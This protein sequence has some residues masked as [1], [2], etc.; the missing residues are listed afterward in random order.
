[1][2]GGLRIFWNVNGGD[3]GYNYPQAKAHGF[4]LI[5]LLN[6][7]SDYPG[8]G[9]EDITRHANANPNNPWA[10]PEF[11]E[12]I[13]RRNIES[14]KGKNAIFVHDIEFHFEDEPQDALARCPAVKPIHDKAPAEFNDSYYREWA[15]WFALPC[16]WTKEIYPN[17]PVGL[18]GPQP[19]R[20]DFWGVAGKDAGQIDGSHRTDGELWRHI[21]PYVDFYIS[22]IY[23]FY[24][25]PG[26]LYY[27][28]ANVEENYLRTRKFGNKPVYAYEWM[29]FHEA[30]KQIGGQEVSPWIAEAMAVIPFFCGGKGIALWGW[31]PKVGGQYYARLPIFLRSLERI[32]RFS[33]KIGRAE[34]V[35]EEPVHQVWKAKKPLVRKLRVTPEEWLVLV[36]NPW[37]GDDAETSVE[38]KIG[39]RT[40]KLSAKGK[41]TE[42]Y[43]INGEKE[44]RLP[45]VA[46]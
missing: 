11:F 18:Y 1:M 24:D 8:K 34:M 25:E 35:A 43:H 37:Q 22:S 20:R 29:R 12:R 46:W 15:Q 2:K 19:F 40:V 41:H 28:G 6:T 9:K 44:E 31:E 5:D 16:R 14:L 3:N 13:V 32:S 26:S 42:I 23:A 7:F 10:R 45:H 33:E 30:N 36:A 38:T 21:D 4:E 27:M 39:N 17:T